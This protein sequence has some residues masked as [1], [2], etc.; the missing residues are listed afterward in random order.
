MLEPQEL[1]QR[2]GDLCASVCSCWHPQ[3]KLGDGPPL[4]PGAS[5]WNPLAGT[6][7]SWGL[8]MLAVPSHGWHVFPLALHAKHA[9]TMLCDDMVD[10]CQGRTRCKWHVRLQPINPRGMSH[11]RLAST[12]WNGLDREGGGGGISDLQCARALNVEGHWSPPLTLRASRMRQK[13][14]SKQSLMP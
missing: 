6:K 4:C 7:R 12:T 1:Q 3:Q 14:F 11:S 13:S 2:S 10:A 9:Q 8:V 5:R